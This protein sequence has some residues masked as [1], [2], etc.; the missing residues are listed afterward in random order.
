MQ[1]GIAAAALVLGLATGARA[2]DEA[3]IGPDMTFTA[4]DGSTMKFGLFAH[5]RYMFNQRDDAPGEDITQGFVNR[6]VK[7]AVQGKIKGDVFGYKLV[8][9][10][11][12]SGGLS[13]EEFIVDIALGETGS[14]GSLK[15]GQFQLPL[16][17]ERL[18]SSSRQLD[19][20]RSLQD[21]VFGQGYSQAVQWSK[22]SERHR[23]YA[24]VSDGLRT[25]DAD[26]WE[27]RESDIALTG[28]AELRLGEAPFKQ[29]DDFT[30]FRGDKCGVLL[31]L[32][33]HWQTGGETGIDTVDQ[34]L[35]EVTADVSVEGD[36]WN[37]YA[38]GI[39]RRSETEDGPEFDDFGVL[40]QGG[41]FVCPDTE[42][43]IR[44]DTIVPDGDRTGGN[45]PFS[46]LTAGFN[47]YVVPR[48]HALKL[49]GD[50][51]VFLNDQEGSG[52]IVRESRGFGLLADSEGGQVLVRIQF[53]IQL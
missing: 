36:G 52:S 21:G 1:Y 38:A 17:R 23:V 34:E 2:L 42:V 28:R 45:D 24:A 31:G 6:R 4:A 16:L 5:F 33:G 53:Q 43:F 3:E 47:H 39:W 22:S 15:I 32:A 30:A 25:I 12:P 11:E 19:V 46:T 14:A 41:V 9:V 49:T 18:V 26:F 8:A 27:S 10:A 37:V 48:S 20:D 7:P 44:W 50:V 35:A 51:V 29:F 13:F 40:V